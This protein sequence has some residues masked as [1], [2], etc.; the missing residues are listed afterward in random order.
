MCFSSRSY[1]KQYFFHFGQELCIAQNVPSASL[2]WC[3]VCNE[4]VDTT[5]WDLCETMTFFFYG[6]LVWI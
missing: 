4:D 1:F 5:C 2:S 3:V 6:G